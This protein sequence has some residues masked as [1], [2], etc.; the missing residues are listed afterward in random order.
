MRPITLAA[1]VIV[2]VGALGVWLV[3]PRAG[4]GPGPGAAPSA[5]PSVPA[6]PWG[7][8]AVTPGS[9][10]VMEAL[11]V[12]TL[13]I[14]DACVFLEHPDGGTTLL[15]WPDDRTSWLPDDRAIVLTNLD[16]R[17]ATFHDGDEVSIGGGAGA[18]SV[19]AVEWV[20]PPSPTCRGDVIWFVG[21]FL[22][23]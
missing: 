16:D 1:V 14:T 21:E 8:L 18:A 6:A 15:A 9:G 10:A 23:D 3:L 19:E 13:R 4:L 12:G 7:P 11:A 22:A 2:L 5:S 17:A 20:A